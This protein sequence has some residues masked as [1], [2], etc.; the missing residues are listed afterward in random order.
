VWC[1]VCGVVDST[2]LGQTVIAAAEAGDY[3]PLHQLQQALASPFTSRAEWKALEGLAP[4]E[5]ERITLSCSS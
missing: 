2:Q 5:S 1:G 3:A 4:E